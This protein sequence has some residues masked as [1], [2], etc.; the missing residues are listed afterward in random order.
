MHI[1]YKAPTVDLTDDVRAYV[2]EKMFAVAK[3]LTHV[4]S[5]NIRI[6]TE[7]SKKADQNSGDIFRTDFTVHAGS[8]RMH[9]VGH[10]ESLFASI[11]E[12]KE[13]LTER[14]R[15]EKGK[16]HDLFIKGAAKIKR[17]IRFWE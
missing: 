14:L 3:L 12:A 4:E 15:R 17:M 13:E 11:D 5:E 9:A 10:G 2:E 16:K 6:E 8:E 1:D 7:L